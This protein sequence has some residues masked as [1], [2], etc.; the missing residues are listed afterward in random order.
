MVGRPPQGTAVVPY[1]NSVYPDTSDDGNWQGHLIRIPNEA[2]LYS[3][4]DLPLAKADY[5]VWGKGLR[6][7]FRLD[8]D[9]ETGDIYIGDV[10]DITIEVLVVLSEEC[11]GAT[12]VYPTGHYTNTE[13]LL[14]ACGTAC[15]Q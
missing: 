14:T 6:N 4:Q 15:F 7:P 13:K 3:A 5:D 10:G 2:L 8:T 9:V 11:S 12:V 1:L